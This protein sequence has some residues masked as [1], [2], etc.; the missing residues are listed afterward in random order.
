MCGACGGG[1]TTWIERVAPLT[2]GGAA[3]RGAA[4]AALLDRA[5]AARARRVRVKPWHGGGWRLWDQ[6]G[7]SFSPSLEAAVAHLTRRYGPLVP[8]RDGPALCEGAGAVP[9]GDPDT[10]APLPEGIPVETVA[11][12]C[13][14]V[15][16]A[17]PVPSGLMVFL[18][19]GTAVRLDGH[20]VEVRTNGRVATAPA[21]HADSGAR[22]LAADIAALAP[23]P[24]RLET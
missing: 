21:L 16:A 6:G 17:A 14:A 3:R 1:A 13:A 24:R 18:P 22:T 4:L 10:R 8:G 19:P 23:A 7:W 11:V 12:W 9:A 20:R 2:G 15:R 5:P